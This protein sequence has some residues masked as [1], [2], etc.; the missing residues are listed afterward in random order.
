MLLDK[1]KCRGS[2][3]KQHS[4]PAVFQGSGM[5]GERREQRKAFVRVY[6]NN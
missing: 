2:E 1:E 3:N 6:L 4:H 5:A